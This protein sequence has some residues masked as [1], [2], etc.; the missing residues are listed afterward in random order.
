MAI[1]T[2]A[3]FIERAQRIHGATYNYG[4]V[5]YRNYDTTVT[6]SCALHGP[7]MQTPGN[8]LKGKGCPGCGRKGA[9]L[10]YTSAE[11]ISECR[12]RHGSKLD[13]SKAEYKGGKSKT[14]FICPEHGAFQ[15][16]PATHLRGKGCPRCAS[17]ITGQ[18]TALTTK[19]F[20]A[21]ASELHGEKY[22][23]SQ[24]KYT[25]TRA[26]M[27]I[28]CPVHGS[29]K[30]SPADHLKGYGCTKCGR[31]KCGALLS[32]GSFVQ[33]ANQMHTG[34]Y[35]YSLV[36]YKGSDKKVSINCP[37]HGV[38]EQTPGNHLSGRGCA[39]CY[40]RCNVWRADK[41]ATLQKGR[42]PLLYIVKLSDASEVFYKV[43]ITFT[44]VRQR[45][46]K[47]RVPYLVQEVAIFTSS[48]PETIHNVESLVKKNFRH[49]RHIPSKSFA[50]RTECYSATEP[51]LL[52]LSKQ[53]AITLIKI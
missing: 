40:E 22:D 6:I 9:A 20:I 14:T 43:G 28:T 32:V 34:K 49:L 7:F 50:G 30:Q 47:S 15:Q 21:K 4:L 19:Q 17:Q 16:T 42:L 23:Y 51:L 52:F 48:E 27:H 44:S 31:K 39:K 11:F 38:F 18:L 46:T 24:A 41:W 53:A 25:N 5:A 33:R 26:K 45:L 10:A 35:D 8:H 12:N 2:T 29:F 37:Q 3:I 1:L 36:K 13:Y